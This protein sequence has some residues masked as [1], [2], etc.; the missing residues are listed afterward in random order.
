MTMMVSHHYLLR[1]YHK[2]GTLYTLFPFTSSEYCKTAV[3]IPTVRMDKLK[4][5]EMKWLSEVT[6]LTSGGAD[7]RTIGLQGLTEATTAPFSAPCTEQF[8]QCFLREG[9][10]Q[11]VPGSPR[12]VFPKSY[13]SLSPHATLGAL[14]MLAHILRFAKL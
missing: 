4:L 5:R 14:H 12:A 13:L 9:V 3:I 6:R 11:T 1:T 2:P 8:S 7:G 10:F